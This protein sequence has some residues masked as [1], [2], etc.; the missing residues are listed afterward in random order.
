MSEQQHTAKP[1]AEVGEMNE[2]EA[3]KCPVAHDRA[4]RPGGTSNEEW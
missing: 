4:T 1:D 3:A 2:P